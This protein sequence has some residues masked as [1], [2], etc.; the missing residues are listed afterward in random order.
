M[1]YI[2]SKNKKEKTNKNITSF[3]ITVSFLSRKNL[4]ELGLRGGWR[5]D[6]KRRR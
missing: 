1:N 6:E 3:D 2:T 4:T 5:C